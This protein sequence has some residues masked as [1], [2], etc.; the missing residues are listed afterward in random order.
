MTGNEELF[1]FVLISTSFVIFSDDGKIFV[2]SGVGEKFGP[3]CH[4]GMQR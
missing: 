3:K 4:T 1:L 2:G